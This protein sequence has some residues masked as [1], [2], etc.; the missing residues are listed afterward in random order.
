MK[1]IEL[2]KISKDVL[3]MVSKSDLKVKDWQHLEMYEEYCLMRTASEKFRY[4]IAH[5]AEK[6]RISESTVKRVIRR[7]S[8]EVTA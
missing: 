6:Y 7:F 5:L 3:K 1:G 4:V 8:K 2:M